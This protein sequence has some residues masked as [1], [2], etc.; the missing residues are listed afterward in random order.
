MPF[1][2]SSLKIVVTAVSEGLITIVPIFENKDPAGEYPRTATICSAALPGSL[3]TGSNLYYSQ[4]DERPITIDADINGLPFVSNSFY[5][6][7]CDST[8]YEPSVHIIDNQFDL[9]QSVPVFIPPTMATINIIATDISQALITVVPT[10]DNKISGGTYPLGVISCGAVPAGS[11]PS[12]GVLNTFSTASEGGT[13]SIISDF[14]GLPLVPGW[15][16]IFCDSEADEP[17]P[18]G[19]GK[20]SVHGEILVTVTA[21]GPSCTSG[22]SMSTAGPASAIAPMAINNHE[23]DLGHTHYIQFTDALA[24]MEAYPFPRPVAAGTKVHLKCCAGE[25]CAFAFA[26]YRC[27]ACTGPKP[28][29]M[30]KQLLLDNWESASCSP[31]FDEEFSTTLFYKNVQGEY[32]RTFELQHNEV[33]VVLMKNGALPVPICNKPHGP[34]P[35][36]G[37]NCGAK[38]PSNI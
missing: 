38:C 37:A 14:E 9:H 20:V 32:D 26:L 1:P 29:G 18:F 25:D 15:Y 3:A 16:S 22:V 24:S 6:I 11:T 36:G 27:E 17:F 30:T 19:G 10:F 21:S 33:F 31:K 7:S 13:V 5:T 28:F 8:V 2:M 35:A 34:F 4:F 12:G 23:L